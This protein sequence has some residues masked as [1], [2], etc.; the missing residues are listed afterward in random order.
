MGDLGPQIVPEHVELTAELLLIAVPLLLQLLL[1][2]VK[3]P[4]QSCSVCFSGK[5][6]L[7][8]M[9][10]TTAQDQS[11]VNANAPV[12]LCLSKALGIATGDIREK[13]PPLGNSTACIKGKGQ[14]ME[15]GGEAYDGRHQQR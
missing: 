11:L 8:L 12:Y 9:D 3:E 6:L 15:D 2:T 4:F 7:H 14:G 10:R 5:S 13:S 1:K